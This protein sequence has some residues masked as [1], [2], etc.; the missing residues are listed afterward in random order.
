MNATDPFLGVLSAL[1]EALASLVETNARLVST[2][3]HREKTISILNSKILCL[4][5]EN[6]AGKVMIARLAQPH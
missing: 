4:E 3:E 5:S 2:I 1:T 6:D